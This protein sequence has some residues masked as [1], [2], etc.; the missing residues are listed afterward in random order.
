MINVSLISVTNSSQT[1][2]HLGTACIASYLREKNMQVSLIH[3]NAFLPAEELVEQLPVTDLYF[4][5]SLCITN[6]D[7]V[8]KVAELLKKRN[9][10]SKIFLGGHLATAAADQILKACQYI[11]F[12]VLGDGEY[13]VEQ[14]LLA[15]ENNKDISEL[16]SIVTR[17]CVETKVP[18]T[19]DMKK[20]P[21][22]SRDYLVDSISKGNTTARL[23]TSRGCCAH[24]SFCSYNL[25]SKANHTKR[26]Q[27]REVE[28]IFNEIVHIHKTYGIRSFSFNDGSL[29]DPGRLGKQRLKELCER[30][31]AYGVPLHF[32][33]FFRAETFSEEDL[34]LIR[35]LRKAGFTQVYIGIEAY[36]KEELDL[37]EKLADVK[38]N[39]KCFN[40]YMNEDIEA[41]IGFI[42]ISP[43]SSYETLRKNYN[44]LTTVDAYCITYYTNQLQIYYGTPIQY[45]IEKLGL[46]NEDYNYDK[47]LNYRFLNPYIEDICQFINHTLDFSELYKQEMEF[48]EFIHF[49]NILNALFPNIANK[50][51]KELNQIKKDYSIIIADFFRDIFY[52][53]N[54]KKAELGFNDFCQEYT[55]IT[56]RFRQMYMSL[57]IKKAVREY[58]MSI[59]Q[60][61]V[62]HEKKH[63]YYTVVE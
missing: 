43:V 18:A 3:L 29:E 31:I 5:F 54:F 48:T 34:P 61:N 16:P 9:S 2:E 11:D 63:L 51:K 38:S 60:L 57:I 14:V 7:K 59:N 44:Y 56:D 37:Y 28:D 35:L 20:M 4:G 27:G 55:R 24:C 49:F 36:N 10:K 62:S 32:R 8:Y 23:I 17:D 40:L 45:K 58:F 47:P 30:I 33:C 42:M 6:Y 21:W 22:P 39:E 1:T 52:E 13:P 46:L 19:V 15:L 12:I 50:Y 26:W 41:V 25:F 53:Q